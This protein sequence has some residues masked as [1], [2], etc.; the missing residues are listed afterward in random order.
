M[1]KNE[2]SFQ[3]CALQAAP[4]E[5]KTVGV[6][7]I[8]EYM[9]RGIGYAFQTVNE[10]D[11]PSPITHGKRNRRWLAGDVVD[12][13]RKKSEQGNA[14]KSTAQVINL[15]YAPHKIEFRERRTS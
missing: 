5:F 4:W 3:S 1:N 8:A 12:Y 9:S 11:F 15:H 7:E 14:A 10:T 6:Q 13:L 2:L